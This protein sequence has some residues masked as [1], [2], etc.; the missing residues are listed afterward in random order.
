MGRT[1]KTWDGEMN[2]DEE[3][4][5]DRENINRL[6]VNGKKKYT[7]EGKGAL[8]YLQN[9]PYILYFNN[10]G[11]IF[12]KLTSPLFYFFPLCDVFCLLIMPAGI[13]V[14]GNIF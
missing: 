6:S 2:M 1:N 10:V 12:N 9:C 11:I 5:K 8:F 4:L 7:W 14:L 3:I 13:R